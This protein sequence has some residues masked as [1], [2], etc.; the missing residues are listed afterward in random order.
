MTQRARRCYA[1]PRS[2]LNSQ[3]ES[4]WN[5]RAIAISSVIPLVSAKIVPLLES[6]EGSGDCALSASVQLWYLCYRK[7]PTAMTAAI[8]EE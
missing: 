1:S 2:P 8:S 3:R 5:S 6:N 7:P 4:P